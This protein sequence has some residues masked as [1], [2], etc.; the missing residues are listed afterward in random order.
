MSQVDLARIPSDWPNR[1]CSRSLTV[2]NLNW[3]VQVS[4]AGPTVLLLHGSGSSAHSWA[5]LFP[6]LSANATV[7]A[8]DLPGHGFTRGASHAVLNLPQI[9]S[10]IDELLRALQLP[11]P[12]LVAGHS[13]GAPLALCWSLRTPVPPRV[14]VGFNPA[15]IA[16]PRG[17]T[18]LIAPWVTPLATSPMFASLI[19]S[20]SA[21]TGLVGSLLDSTQSAVPA[22]QRDRYAALFRNAEH[23]RGTMGFMAAADL[24]RILRDASSLA[25]SLHFVLGANDAW[26]PLV[27][28]RNVIA[29][30][31]P[32]ASV[33][34]WDG[35]H[36]LHE[37]EP[38]RVAALLADKIRAGLL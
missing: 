23:V 31:L 17:Y 14:I 19:A 6:A 35:G 36:L 21:R 37:V 10:D 22:A 24:A 2:G 1:A 34:I 5:D 30:H 27:P 12:V 13:A 29:G 28:L 25:V 7:V 26:V 16:P 33:E 20:L 32:G 4:G 11:P 18:E 9:A 3:H 8:P 15:L 38:A